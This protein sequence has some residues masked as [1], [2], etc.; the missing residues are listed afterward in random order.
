MTVTHTI[1]GNEIFTHTINGNFKQKLLSN[2]TIHV[3]VSA[4]N[5]GIDQGIA[6]IVLAPKTLLAPAMKEVIADAASG[7]AW[8]N[9]IM[10]QV[11][12]TGVDGSNPGNIFH[13]VSTIEPPSPVLVVIVATSLSMIH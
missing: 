12:S 8:V 1:N 4:I 13:A 2:W 7:G 6:L 3:V 5:P 10:R 11:S 9:K